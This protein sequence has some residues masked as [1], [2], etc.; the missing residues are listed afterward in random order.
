MTRPVSRRSTDLR[1]T[2]KVNGRSVHVKARVPEGP[3]RLD[4]L[5]PALYVIDDRLIETAIARHEAAG[6]HISCRKGCSACCRVQPV[7]VIPPEAFALARL[8]DA[9]PE[10]RQSA[11]RA[12]F[13]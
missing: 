6:E 2:F 11:V 1:V 13:A 3:A 4:E 8:V 9:L 5:L 10:R 12:A 7:P